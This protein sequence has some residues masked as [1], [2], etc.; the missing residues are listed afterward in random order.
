MKLG[1]VG[2]PNVGKSTLLIHLLRQEQSQLTIL[3]VQLTLMSVLLQFR[4]T[5]LTSL[6]L[7]IIQQR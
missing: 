3:S 2:L 1:I 5:D 4:M 7:Y 6:P